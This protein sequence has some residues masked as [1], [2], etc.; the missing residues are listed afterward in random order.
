MRCIFEDKA[1]SVRGDFT[2]GIYKHGKLVQEYSDHNLVVFSGRHR[3]AEMAAGKSTS[4]ISYIGVGSG[5]EKCTNHFGSVVPC[6]T[7][8]GRTLILI[9]II[10]V[11]SARI[12]C[13]PDFLNS[14]VGAKV[15]KFILSFF[16]NNFAEFCHT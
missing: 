16:L 9:D 4:H 12:Y 6:R 10:H 13:V 15:V 2:L 7:H 3:L 14:S 11:N 8:E 1:E 5:S